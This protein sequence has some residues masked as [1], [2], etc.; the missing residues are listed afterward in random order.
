VTIVSKERLARSGG[1][2]LS[3][4]F[5]AFSRLRPAEKPLHPRGR[6]V[7]AR[8]ARTG[9]AA[10]FGVAWLD[11]PGAEDVVVRF[12]RGV[13][14]P[15]GLPDVLGMAVRIPTVTGF[16]DLLFSTTG[17]GR[18][19]RFLMVPRRRYAPAWYGT[20]MPYRSAA[21]PVL[22]A[23]AARPLGQRIT[24]EL[25]AARPR[26]AWQPFASF[27]AAAP[28]VHTSDRAI[29]FEPM[30]HFP[31]GLEPYQWVANLREGAY[32]A[33]RRARGDRRRPGRVA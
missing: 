9:A 7:D 8:L 4:L 6:V 12:S 2:A 26:G 25:L 21:G 29:T 10:P 30:A 28:D 18:V 33:A 24:V 3:A 27:S 16:A 22:L 23:A 13:G 32:A 19:T 20:L 1:A 17:R 15:S 31:P 11:E 14:L 5:T